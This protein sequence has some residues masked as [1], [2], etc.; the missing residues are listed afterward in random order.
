MAAAY[1]KTHCD[2]KEHLL[3]Y[4]GELHD[5]S[6]SST[7]NTV[8]HD[9]EKLNA[10]IAA[11]KPLIFFHN[12]PVDHGRAAMFPSQDDF[13]VAALFL[14]MVYR[15]N[16]QLSVEFRV[17]QP[18]DEN[19]VVSYGF[20]GSALDEIKKLA[21]EYRIVE[22]NADSID[23]KRDVLDERLAEESFTDYLQHACRVDL[24]RKDDEVC[25]THPQNF[26][27]PSDRFFVRNRPQH[28]AP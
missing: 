19:T 24:T 26:L 10:V 4:N 28:A 13:G 11:A 9:P 23:A 5:I 14:S 6:L 15:K 2:G 12:H 7:R 8:R 20:K 27:W 22:A 18:G 17:V 21:L 16:P 1:F 3:V 25:R